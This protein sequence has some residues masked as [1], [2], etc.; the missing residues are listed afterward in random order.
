MHARKRRTWKVTIKKKIRLSNIMMVL[1]PILFTTIVL[2]VFLNTSLGSYWHTFMDMYSDENGV[3]FAQSMIYNYQQELWENNWGHC[4]EM[5][6]CQTEIR[7][8]DEM[9]HLENK[10]SGLG[11]R[12]MITKNGESIFC[13]TAVHPQETDGTMV[14]YLKS[15]ILRYLAGILLLFVALTVCINGILSWWISGSILKPLG[16]LSL[17][18]KEIREGNLDT[19]MQYE[20]KDE[21]GQV[22]REF[23][24]MR[25]YLQESVQ[26]RLKDEK[27]RLDTGFR[28]HMEET[29]FRD[30]V[31]KYLELVRP[32]MEN[33]QVQTEYFCGKGSFLVRLD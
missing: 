13:I 23:D 1:I 27:R 20:K 9:T 2:I 5:D 29:D 24:E 10:L 30:Y 16:K 11:Y 4:P 14:N 26:Q 28:Y 18:T 7:H 22:C 33:Q 8:S 17:G 25:A 21:F 15:I 19:P 6:A 32:D 3:Q 31:E 12:F